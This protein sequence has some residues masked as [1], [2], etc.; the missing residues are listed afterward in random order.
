MVVVGL[1]A[2]VPYL[3]FVLL[4]FIAD[5][6]QQIML[7]RTYGPISQWP[8][9]AND[10][11]YRSRA[12]SIF[13]T[14]LADQVAGPNPAFHHTVNLL[15][16]VI[17]SF[18]IA[19]LGNWKRIGW[20]VSIPSAVAF[21]LC[22]VHQEAVI[23]VAALPELLVFTFVMLSLLS[24]ILALKQRSPFL[25]AVSLAAFHLALLSKESA[26]VVLPI[27]IFIWLWESREWPLPVAALLGMTVSTVVYS[28]GI[29]A[30]ANTHLHLND[31]TFSFQAPF[32][33][34]FCQSFG[35][36]LFPWG[37]IS[38]SILA[39]TQ[40]LH[41]LTLVKMSLVWIAVSLLPY[42]FLTYMERVPSRHTYLASVGLSLIV[43]TAYAV[44]RS[45]FHSNKAALT[46]VF[47]LAFTVQNLSYLWT[48]KYDQYSRRV[49]P[50]EKF[51]R[52]A[53]GSLLTPVRIVCAP[54]GYEAF[55]YTAQVRLGKPSYFVLGPE[56]DSSEIEPRDY[57]DTSIP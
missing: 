48:K 51:L 39:A 28:F 18:L 26:V 7:G 42:C 15:L 50:T 8:E 55:R 17:N 38:L 49:E 10:V 37:L 54:Y 44:L 46:T 57:C 20:A 41:S 6:Y 16:H 31:G 29:F 2:I 40:K 25:L 24:W 1:A 27:A 23:W 45:S 5:S 30:A 11:L 13:V 56:E 19:L 21:A 34:V 35:R 14:F 3:P 36:L 33:L 22:E 12:T 47:A 43:G 53:E 32:F 9:L 52:F 4:P